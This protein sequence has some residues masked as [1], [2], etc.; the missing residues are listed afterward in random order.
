MHE[1]EDHWAAHSAQWHRLVVG[2]LDEV[3]VRADQV[4]PALAVAL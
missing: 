2:G 4:R 3:R 1:R